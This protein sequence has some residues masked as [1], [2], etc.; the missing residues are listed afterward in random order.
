MP[1]AAAVLLRNDDV[2]DPTTYATALLNVLADFGEEKARLQ[3]TQRAILN[4]LG[5]ANDE[6]K[7]LH[8]IHG[9]MLNILDDF[10]SDKIGLA[11]TQ[12]ARS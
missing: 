5:D 7:H 2:V 4:I 8:D 3:A 11:A 1:T 6:A 10:E 12:A 9:A